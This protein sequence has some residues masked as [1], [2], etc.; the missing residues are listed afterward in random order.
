MSEIADTD[1]RV[2][3]D[4][5]TSV[6]AFTPEK[7]PALRHMNLP[8]QQEFAIDHSI[9]HI[10]KTLGKIATQS[11]ARDHGGPESFDALRTEAVKLTI[12]A[13][14]LAHIVGIRADELP[15]L[16]RKLVK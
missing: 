3:M 1:L 10:A 11:E 13:L 9:K 5:I 12:T 6:F 14:N 4:R 8:R 7:Y 16:I 2:V 15:D